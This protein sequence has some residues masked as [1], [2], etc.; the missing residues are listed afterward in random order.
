MTDILFI[1]ISLLVI[2]LSTGRAL[3]PTGLTRDQRLWAIY[4]DVARAGLMD[5][6]LTHAA[7]AP[8]W[9]VLRSLNPAHARLGWVPT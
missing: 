6:W 5:G 2:V 3:H 7:V 4:N 8:A 1:L 9:A